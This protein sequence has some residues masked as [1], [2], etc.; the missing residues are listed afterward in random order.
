MG[1][2]AGSPDPAKASDTS[3]SR[4]GNAQKNA[5]LVDQTK[6]HTAWKLAG[7]LADRHFA[8]ILDR[9]LSSGEHR[10]DLIPLLSDYAVVSAEAM[11]AANTLRSEDQ[12]LRASK[13]IDTQIDSLLEIRLFVPK[14]YVGRW[15]WSDLMVAYTPAGKSKRWTTIEAFD[16]TGMS[17]YLDARTPPSTPVLVAG[18]NRRK[19][20]RAGVAV[21]NK[22]LQAQGLQL[23]AAPAS[24]VASLVTAEASIE[25]TRLDR[26]TLVNDQE[27]WISGAAEI[28]A[29][30]SG[31]QPD[32]AQAAL[33]VVDMPYLDDDATT[34]TPNQIVIFWSSYRFAAANLQLFEHDDNTDYQQLALALSQGVTSILGAFAPNITVIGQVA[35][36]ILQAMP[37]STF[38]NDDD[39][40]DS[41]YTLEKNRVYTN[42]VGVAQNATVSLTPYLLKGQ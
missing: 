38:T 15:N 35:T 4:T 33:T 26:I 20:L 19:D 3:G 6:R 10:A 9:H 13:G 32:Q 7:M 34:Y 42:Y 11:S 31:I 16:R 28:Y 39:Y 40:V 25:T 27:P 37:A 8:A 41:F 12:K 2:L 14:G 24:P 29:V 18:I 5:T 36:A 1:A 30:V 21:M 22:H 23:A 17:H